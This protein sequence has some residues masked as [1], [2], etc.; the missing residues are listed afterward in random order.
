MNSAELDQN[1]ELSPGVLLFVDDEESILRTLQRLFIPLGYEVHTASS[2]ADGLEILEEYEVDLVISDMRMPEMDGA[3][4]LKAA[5]EKWPETK[6]MLL[7]GYAEIES[8][9]SAI[10]DGKVHYYLNKP[11]K[12]NQLEVAVQN[13]LEGKRLKDENLALQ[14]KITEQNEQLKDLNQSLEARVEEKTAELQEA[15]EKLIA[16]FDA[17]VQ[18]L[19]RLVE[20]QDTEQNCNSREIAKQAQEVAEAMELSETECQNVYLAGLL[21]KIGKIGMSAAVLNES[22]VKLKPKDQAEYIKYPI[23]GNAALMTFEPLKQVAEI[24]LHHKEKLDGTGYPSRAKGE[25]IPI[26]SQILGAIVD[27]HE[28]QTGLLVDG[29]LSVNQSLKYLASNQ[30]SSYNAK[31]VEKFTEYVEA[32]HTGNAALTEST[33]DVNQLAVGMVLTQD[34]KSESGVML[35]PKGQRI[36]GKHVDTIQRL[37][38]EL[39]IY[40]QSVDSEDD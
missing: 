23:L 38:E 29:K 39:V 35:L 31:V 19:S 12:E 9:I 28:L 3:A 2:G 26:E 20:M 10:N 24:I 27:Y 32:T 13:A 17:S 5:A 40:I 33:I 7:T 15:H 11:W 18:V 4:F 36:S 22:F 14:S 37:G 1:D 21:Y 16:D 34:L 25:A 6:R 30:D 8:A